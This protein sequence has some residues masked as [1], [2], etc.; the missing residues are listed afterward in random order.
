MHFALITVDLYGVRRLYVENIA[1]WW[2]ICAGRGMTSDIS[3]LQRQVL[4]NLVLLNHFIVII[5]NFSSLHEERKRLER[6]ELFYL[7]FLQI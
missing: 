4:I 2:F 6:F 3:D 1:S 7:F 5:Y